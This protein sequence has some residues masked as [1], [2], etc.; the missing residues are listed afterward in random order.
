[1]SEEALVEYLNSK[2]PYYMIPTQ[3]IIENNFALNTSGKVDR[4]CLKNQLIN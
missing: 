3:I 1:M 4:I 2:M